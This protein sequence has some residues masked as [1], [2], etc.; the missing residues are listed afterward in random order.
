LAAVLCASSI[1]AVISGAGFSQ[2]LTAAGFG[3]LGVAWFM[4]PLVVTKGLGNALRE[5]ASLAIGSTKLRTWL[6]G[7][8]LALLVLAFVLRASGVA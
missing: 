8:G 5:S 6:G 2:L 4:Q 3:M 1:H 7:L